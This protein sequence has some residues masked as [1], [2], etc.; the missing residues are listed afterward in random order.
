M[1]AYAGPEWQVAPPVVEQDAAGL[2]FPTSIPQ[3]YTAYPSLGEAERVPPRR[4]LNR[5]VTTGRFNPPRPRS[6]EG[7]RKA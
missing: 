6:V 5:S 3:I 1:S 2:L 4:C 7:K